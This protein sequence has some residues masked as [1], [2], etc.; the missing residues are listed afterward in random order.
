M[1][2]SGPPPERES[3]AGGEEK[4]PSFLKLVGEIITEEIIPEAGE[5]VA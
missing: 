5:G 2:V 1:S 3:A 4:E